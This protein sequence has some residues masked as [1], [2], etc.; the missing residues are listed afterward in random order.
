[1]THAF[2]P[3]TLEREA[4]GSLA[5][6][7]QLGLIGLWTWSQLPWDSPPLEEALILKES[8]E[9]PSVFLATPPPHL[10]FF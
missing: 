6:Q 1:M 9:S 5:V 10:I 4:V 8:R 7:D 3:S 2:N